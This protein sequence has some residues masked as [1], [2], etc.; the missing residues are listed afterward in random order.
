MR[1]RLSA[2]FLVLSF[3]AAILCGCGSQTANNSATDKAKKVS[4]QKIETRTAAQTLDYFGYVTA[5]ETKKYSFESGGTL[6][7]VYIKEGQQITKGT[8]LACLDTTYLQMAVDNSSQTVQ[9]AKNGLE[10]A[11]IAVTAQQATL[12]KLRSS[13]NAS[14]DSLQIQCD[15]QQQTVDRDQT[16]YAGGQIGLVELNA[17]T[18][19]MDLLKT[20]MVSTKASKENDVK[21]QTVAVESAKQQVSAAQLAVTQTNIGLAQSQ[22][23]LHDATLV[24]NE[25]GYVMSV[26]YKTGEVVGSGCPV[27]IIKMTGRL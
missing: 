8:A 10:T 20:Q 16:L 11:Q 2:L 19:Q 9:S 4:S 12:D 23:T 24:A 26:A 25:D 15:Q 22:K 21:A 27:V 17:A 6:G 5:Q 13:Y 18:A 7:D 14:I 3:L 1:R